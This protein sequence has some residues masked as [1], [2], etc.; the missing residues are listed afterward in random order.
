MFCSYKQKDCYMLPTSHCFRNKERK[1]KHHASKEKKKKGKSP[2]KGLHPEAQNA[3][4]R[5]QVQSPETH[6]VQM[7]CVCHYS[8]VVH[9]LLL[10]REKAEK[11]KRKK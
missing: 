3:Q 9:L 6:F 11:R 7:K 8:F 10:L 2:N 5:A 4:W 1:K